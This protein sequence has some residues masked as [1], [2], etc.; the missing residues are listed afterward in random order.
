MRVSNLILAAVLLL[1]AGPARAVDAANTPLKPSKHAALSF[2]SGKPITV[3]VVDTPLDRERGLMFYTKL[4]R[5]Y[6]M[7]FAF[8]RE[9]MMT[10]WMKN[11]LIPLDIVFIGADKKITVIH[12]KMKASTTET[13]DDA[14]ARA[15]GTAQYVLELPAGAAKR[16]KLAAGDALKFTVDIPEQ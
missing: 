1:A 7:L 6:G 13:P 15:G 3:D 5:D 2:P 10:F 12:A 16:R 8:P 11:T 14:V 9:M 4:P